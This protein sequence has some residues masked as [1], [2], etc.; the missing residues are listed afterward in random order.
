MRELLRLLAVAR[1]PI[2]SGF[3]ETLAGSVSI[4]AYGEADRFARQAQ[5][6]RPTRTERGGSWYTHAE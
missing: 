1:S 6:R 2:Y 3:T 4:R 5:L